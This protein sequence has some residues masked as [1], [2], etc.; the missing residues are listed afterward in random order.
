MQLLKGSL[1]EIERGEYGMAALAELV[2]RKWEGYA[3]IKSLLFR[4]QEVET[5]A[6]R[7]IDSR[8]LARR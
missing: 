1:R 2:L 8:T 5:E 3:P 6:L 4:V 7:M